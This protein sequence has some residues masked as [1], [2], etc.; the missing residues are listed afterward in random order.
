MTFVSMERLKPAPIAHRIAEFTAALRK[1]L[2]DRKLYSTTL[3]ELRAL[4]D[5]ELND[6]G[7]CRSSIVDVARQA[8]YP[9]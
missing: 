4:S 2:A 5:R 6:L 9:N 1:T 3:R 8:V 7:L